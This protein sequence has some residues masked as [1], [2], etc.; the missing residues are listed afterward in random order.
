[1]FLIKKTETRHLE[2]EESFITQILHNTEDNSITHVW[3]VLLT[4]FYMKKYYDIRNIVK[5]FFI[6]EDEM[7]KIK[8]HLTFPAVECE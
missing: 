2:E 4:Q 8:S 6:C 1:M 7:K 5:K 3:N